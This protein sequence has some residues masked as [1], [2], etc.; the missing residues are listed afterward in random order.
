M[1]KTLQDQVVWCARLQRVVAGVVLVAVG[2]FYFLGYRPQTAALR[3]LTADAEAHLL[4]LK[5]NQQKAS[6]KNEIAAK[7]EKLRGELEMYKKPSRQAELPE[8]FK[9]L[10]AFAQQ[11]SLKTFSFSPVI[12]SSSQRNDLYCEVPHRL[13]FDGDFQRVDDFLRAAEGMQRLTRVRSLSIKAT[14]K[15]SE[16]GQVHGEMVMNIYL[17]ASE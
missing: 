12:S 6:H 1:K 9:D 14:G 5:A 4:E 10:S 7:N 11:S 16:T 2:A 3:T 8:I 17:T 13:T 15:S